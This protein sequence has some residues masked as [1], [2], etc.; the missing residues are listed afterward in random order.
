M[1]PSTKS[2]KSVKLFN[3]IANRTKLIM[4]DL[5]TKSKRKVVSQSNAQLLQKHIQL[6][7]LMMNYTLVVAKDAIRLSASLSVQ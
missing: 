2:T 5:S 7:N 4:K 3:T 6:A 1:I